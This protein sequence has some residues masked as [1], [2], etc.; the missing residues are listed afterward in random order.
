MNI[1]FLAPWSLSDPLSISTV[2]PHVIELSSRNTIDNIYLVSTECRL[3]LD[4][5]RPQLTSLPNNV[6]FCPFVS[7]YAGP[8]GYIL[9]DLL[10][11]LFLFR[12]A[13]SHGVS[14][15]ICRGSSSGIYGHRLKALFNL[16]YIVE[17]FEPHADYMLQSGEWKKWGF[18]Y[19][20]QKHWERQIKRTA[21]FL[22]TVSHSYARYLCDIEKLSESR[23][24]T[25]PCWADSD[26]FDFDPSLREFVR[27]KLGIRDRLCLIYVGKFGGLYSPPS[28]LSVL[29]FIEKRLGTD[30]FFI[31]LTPSDSA[32]V[33]EQLDAIGLTADRRFVGKVE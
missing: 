8:F 21:S 32:P 31:C 2:I 6:S 27:S 17:S 3:S 9:R 25:M 22:I 16:P 23:L 33:L 5:C 15:L 28:V 29:R 4:L 30:L 20:V 24:L 1:L 12:L 26:K 10:R 13:R 14:F 7:D 18:K 11:L 19:L